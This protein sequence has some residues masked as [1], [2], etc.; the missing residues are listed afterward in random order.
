M[1]K[2]RFSKNLHVTRTRISKNICDFAHETYDEN[3]TLQ[4]PSC[5]QDSKSPK[6]F[7]HRKPIS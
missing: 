1:T 6:T 5:R 4:K 7:A 2:I 3:Q